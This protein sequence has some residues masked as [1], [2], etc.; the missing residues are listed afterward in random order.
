MANLPFKEDGSYPKDVDTQ[1]KRFAASIISI[2]LR[3]CNCL[4]NCIWGETV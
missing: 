3:H 4:R 2:F 1:I